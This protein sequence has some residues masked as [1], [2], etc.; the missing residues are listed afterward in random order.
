MKLRHLQE[1]KDRTR[2]YHVKRN[3]PDL[4]KYYLFPLIHV[5]IDYLRRG[6][7]LI[8][9][10]KTGKGNGSGGYGQSA[11]HARLTTPE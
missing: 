6:R 1:K 11:V 8:R 10:G 2:G 5:E 4:G 3:K 9:V 7:D